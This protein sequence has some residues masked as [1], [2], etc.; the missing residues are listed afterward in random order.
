MT[1]ERKKPEDVPSSRLNDEDVKQWKRKLEALLKAS[2]KGVLLE[3]WRD[4]LKIV[5]DG[6]HSMVDPI[7]DV[8]APKRLCPARL[9]TDALTRGGTVKLVDAEASAAVGLIVLGV[10]LVGGFVA[11][12]WQFAAWRAVE[13][14]SCASGAE[15]I[16]LVWA[17]NSAYD[18]VSD[19]LR[20]RQ[21]DAVRIADCDGNFDCDVLVA[22]DAVRID[23]DGDICAVVTLTG[24]TP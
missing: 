1:F 9:R 13:E 17:S 7:L 4:G 24:S 10:L 14:A 3:M 11:F 12:M 6:H 23:D 22:G 2:P 5:E 8:R 15:A 16:V 18:L 19:K 21:G 20:I